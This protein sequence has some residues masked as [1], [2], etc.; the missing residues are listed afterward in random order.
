MSSEAAAPRAPLRSS[1]SEC[2]RR[3]PAR[4]SPPASAE[5]AAIGVRVATLNIGGAGRLGAE[6]HWGYLCDAV[7]PGGPLASRDLIFLT[8]VKLADFT[9]LRHL[10]RLLH[11]AQ[12]TVR[13]VERREPDP[14]TCPCGALRCA[15]R[16]KILAMTSASA[17]RELDAER[18]DT[19][20]A[21]NALAQA[22]RQE[23]GGVMAI[24]LNPDLRVQYTGGSHLGILSVKVQWIS[25]TKRAAPDA[26]GRLPPS[27]ATYHPISFLCVYNPCISSTANSTPR[28]AG[29]TEHTHLLLA[30]L[31]AR[32]AEEKRKHSVI[33]L[34]GD[35]N[36]RLGTARHDG[37]EGGGVEGGRSAESTGAAPPGR[38]TA[39][40]PASA[41]AAR[42]SLF[43]HFCASIGATIP[44]GA[45]AHQ[46]P[47]YCTSRAVASSSP[48]VGTAEVDAFLVPWASALAAPGYEW[49]ETL[50]AGGE[51]RLLMRAQ[52]EPPPMGWPASADAGRCS[53]DSPEARRGADRDEAVIPDSMTHIPVCATFYLARVTPPVTPSDIPSAPGSPASHVPFLLEGRRIRRVPFSDAKYHHRT[54]KPLAAWAIKLLRDATASTQKGGASGTAETNTIYA[55]AVRE[56]QEIALRPNGRAASPRVDTSQLPIEARAAATR[57]AHK[58]WSREA[59]AARGAAAQLAREIANQGTPATN[60]QGIRHDALSR[61]AAEADREARNTRREATRLT[62]QGHR[63]ALHELSSALEQNRRRD[64]STFFRQLGAL[65]PA[66]GAHG[67]SAEDAPT[68]PMQDVVQMCK[69]LFTET[70]QPPDLSSWD[71]Y[72]YHGSVAEAD[73]P[74]R[75]SCPDI[76]SDRERLWK[77]VYLFLFPI[78]R[79]YADEYTEHCTPVGSCPLCGALAGEMRRFLSSQTSLTNLPP[80]FPGRLKTS[81]GCGSDSLNPEILSF[82]RPMPPPARR[83]AASAE[84]GSADP[85]SYHEKRLL[86]HRYR[87]KISRAIAAMLVGWRT[88]GIPVDADCGLVVLTT[89]PKP[90]QDPTKADQRRPVSVENLFPKLYDAIVNFR[91]VHHLA[92]RP[93]ALSSPQIGGLPLRSP[94]MHVLNH[95]A[96]IMHANAEGRIVVVIFADIKGAYPCMDMRIFEHLLHKYDFPGHFIR[97]LMDRLSKRRLTVR[98]GKAFSPTIPLTKS[99]QQG[100]VFAP[101]GWALYFDPL[102]RCIEERIS[103]VRV[104]IAP[105]PA[106]LRG[107]RAARASATSGAAA[108]GSDSESES[109]ST[110]TRS[111]AFVDDASIYLSFPG[112]ASEAE[113]LRAIVGVLGILADYESAFRTP[114]AA[115]NNKTAIM[116]FPP[117][118]AT[119]PSE[120]ER[121]CT[122]YRPGIPFPLPHTVWA[123]DGTRIAGAAPGSVGATP[124]LGDARASGTPVTRIIPYVKDYKYL[125]YREARDF[126]GEGVVRRI[127]SSL[128]GTLVRLF[129]VNRAVQRL[130]VAAKMQ[131][132]STLMLGATSYLMSV[133]RPTSEQAKRLEAPVIRT[134][135]AILGAPHNSSRAI[136]AM[137]APPVL[138]C[139]VLSLGHRIRMLF[140][141]W[142]MPPH[143]GNPAA[144]LVRTAMNDPAE[145]GGAIIPRRISGFPF[146]SQIA[147]DLEHEGHAP[148]LRKDAEPRIAWRTPTHPRQIIPHTIQLRRTASFEHLGNLFFGAAW[149]QRRPAVAPAAPATPC[150]SSSASRSGIEPRRDL[151]KRPPH[152]QAGHLAHIY[153]AA[154]HAPPSDAGTI[155]AATPLS[156]V[157]PGGSGRLL[158]LSHALTADASV[159]ARARAGAACLASRPF[160]FSHDIEPP[161][162]PNEEDARCRVCGEEAPDNLLMLC[163]AFCGA[164]LHWQTRCAGADLDACM[165]GGT[166]SSILTRPTGSPGSASASA[167]RGA[168]RR[169]SSTRP[170]RPG[171]G[172]MPRKWLCSEAC[173][174]RYS[175]FMANYRS[176]EPSFTYDAT[177]RSWGICTICPTGR[178]REREDIWHLALECEN[179]LMRELRGSLIV[180]AR[181]HMKQSVLS[182]RAA[183]KRGRTWYPGHDA[184]R[185]LSAT[186]EALALLDSAAHDNA[187]ERDKHLIY[188]MILALPFPEGV[189]PPP[190]ALHASEARGQLLA[191]DDLAFSRAMGRVYDSVVLPNVMLHRFATLA[192][193]WASGWIREIAST[194]RR[195]LAAALPLRS[196]SS[197]LNPR[198]SEA[199]PAPPARA[200]RPDGDSDPDLD[201]DIPLD[202]EGDPGDASEESGAQHPNREALPS[203]AR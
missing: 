21:S 167:A 67:S 93:A 148:A 150:R 128:N 25:P 44:H 32:V 172:R 181:A 163:H 86:V 42:T 174:R 87:E 129:A 18:T 123:A 173:R 30:E 98:Q 132:L 156:W 85:I 176:E 84:T 169:V 12:Y 166:S 81:K 92:S 38:I 194:R 51:G 203:P 8:E 165:A 141:L 37:R 55:N 198:L 149:S 60:R 122:P 200:L 146:V 136:V 36:M 140:A 59:N 70:R 31:R 127:V 69:D 53:R 43:A 102:I 121:C 114:F 52:A 115:G 79:E 71:R 145:H 35:W 39:D 10:G 75:T 116:Y 40:T 20:A 185:P 14:A 68:P 105:S 77:L 56:L 19:G 54:S 155:P 27:S 41:A 89:L 160:T 184:A 76:D 34:C 50:A 187:L 47:G 49:A 118:G 57:R 94:E 179:P 138:P 80:L 137:E 202:D 164:A 157:G 197:G 139:S 46:T 178:P 120:V 201:N 26:S 65:A 131:L 29:K 78:T 82:V 112:D 7:R 111:M 175:E 177:T 66:G 17:A 188:R 28:S 119:S 6:H 154:A 183:V 64:P 196:P 13:D 144:S 182:L 73:R 186:G 125:G 24:P 193:K 134:M 48:G 108:A 190:P 161:L 104:N 1:A 135:R 63:H 171:A 130:H 159:V 162:N 9:L 11:R 168:S 142:L 88:H 153:Y 23:W 45:A 97:E 3:A 117:G 22:R 191:T 110:A 15:K 189:I 58:R 96:V 95:R 113:I 109:A 74:C 62:A 91:M 192:V 2:R 147:N 151:M 100:Q 4:A 5:G 143:A 103:G 199:R 133:Q 33:A 83:S 107:A 180:S 158:A 152:D 124:P 195:A 101:T 61:A 90:G 106:A 126:S 72:T 16:V 99:L 170:T